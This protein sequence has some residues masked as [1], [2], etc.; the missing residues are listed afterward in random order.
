[1]VAK[2]DPDHLAVPRTPE[3][4]ARNPVDDMVG[5]VVQEPDR[6]CGQ[7]AGDSPAVGRLQL[8][9]GLEGRLWVHGITV[10]HCNPAWA[11]SA[12]SSK[13]RS[14]SSAP[15]GPA[16]REISRSPTSTPPSRT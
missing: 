14:S 8:A 10:D 1:M 11:G 5:R 7:H 16:W 4:K 15:G 2:G 9:R 3:G 13:A 12:P 6:Q